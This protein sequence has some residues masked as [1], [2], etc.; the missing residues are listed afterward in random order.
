LLS[1]ISHTNCERCGKCC[2]ADFIAYVR[3]EDIDRWHREG[4]DD[5]LQMI[6]RE[7]ALW[8]G[9]HLVCA[10]DGRYLRGCPFLAFEETQHRCSIYATR[11][12]VCRDYRPGSSEICPKFHR[13][14]PRSGKEDMP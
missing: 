5:I 6:R 1:E 10:D 12:R 3:D 7:H 13:R 4:R 9:D 14:Y 2:L 11:P 8:M